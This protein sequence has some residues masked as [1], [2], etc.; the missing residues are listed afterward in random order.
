M[1]EKAI[2]NR[3]IKYC[4]AKFISKNLAQYF[5]IIFYNNNYA[6]GRTDEFKNFW[7]KYKM[8]PTGYPIR[9]IKNESAL[10]KNK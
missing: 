1:S 4:Y 9:L 6:F 5:D 8:V 3:Y 10:N 7:N 2:I